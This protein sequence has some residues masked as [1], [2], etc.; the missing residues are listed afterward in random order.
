MSEYISIV[1]WFIDNTCCLCAFDTKCS[2][3]NVATTDV[4][5][6][7]CAAVRRKLQ[8]YEGRTE[9]N[10][11][12]DTN[13]RNILSPVTAQCNVQSTMDDDG[14]NGEEQSS[15]GKDGGYSD[16]SSWVQMGLG[17]FFSI[18]FQLENYLELILF[19][20]VEPITLG[21]FPYHGVG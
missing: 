9:A 1:R 20:L 6:M 17:D 4:T 16:N 21:F 12:I 15:E 2:M 18:E 11:V 19:S 8:K 5:E 14:G 13:F 7:Y 3:S 10:Y